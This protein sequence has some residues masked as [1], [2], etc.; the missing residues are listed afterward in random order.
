MS[1]KHVTL[2]VHAHDAK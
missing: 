2:T 1:S